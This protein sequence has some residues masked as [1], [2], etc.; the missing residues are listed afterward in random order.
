MSSPVLLLFLSLIKTSAQPV[1]KQHNQFLE[2]VNI[3]VGV[4]I[5]NQ[6]MLKATVFPILMTHLSNTYLQS[7]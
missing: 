5:L 6:G 1:P 3:N 4:D 7:L 2:V